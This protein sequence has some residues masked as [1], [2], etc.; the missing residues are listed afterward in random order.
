MRWTHRIAVGL[1]LGLDAWS[2]LLVAQERLPNVR[3]SAKSPCEIHPETALETADLWI[4]AREALQSASDTTGTPPTLLIQEWRRTLDP[5]MR[6]RWE[7]RDTARVTTFHP[8]EKPQPSL[9]RA[10]YIQRQGWNTVYYGPDSGLL[11]S[12]WF[13]RRHC[14]SRIAGY[15]GTTGLVGLGFEPLPGTRQTDVAGVLWI[16]PVRGELR[17][18]EYGWTNP[19][20]E[21]RAVG[22]GGRADFVRLISGGWIVQRWNIR[23]PHPR[24]ELDDSFDGYTD[25]GGEV[26]AVGT[27]KAKASKKVKP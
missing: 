22:V 14:F 6:L 5:R 10:G 21:A 24:P 20:E 25:Q 7:R 9:E 18:V 16:D 26:V 3:V 8:F 11:L 12:E 19:P 1:L 17:H 15:G 2:G 23:M 4:A 13:L 27:R